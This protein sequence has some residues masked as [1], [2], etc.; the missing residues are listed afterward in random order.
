MISN[1][2]SLFLPDD[3][4]LGGVTTIEFQLFRH[5]QAL[6]K[7]KPVLKSRDAPL[8]HVDVRTSQN[9]FQ[10]GTL[11]SQYDTLIRPSTTRSTS[12]GFSF[13]VSSRKYKRRD[14]FI[15]GEHE[16]ECEILRN[17]LQSVGKST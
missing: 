1:R 17:K 6:K 7:A 9:R 12:T 13:P 4:N 10:N 8:A 2:N 16:R 11:Q 3:R 15:R 14:S 5:K